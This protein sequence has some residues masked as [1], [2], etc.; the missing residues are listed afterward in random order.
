MNYILLL[1][2][3]VSFST[4]AEELPSIDKY[5]I[6][7]NTEHF[8]DNDEYINCA[9]ITR[10]ICIQSFETAINLCISKMPQENRVP[11]PVCISDNYVKNA[12]INKNTIKSCAHITAKIAEE[13]KSKH[14]PNKAFNNDAQ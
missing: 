4:V 14:M 2:L 10:A 5:L 12:D 7:F 9:N 3:S 1:L 8:C 11:S 6:Q 13:F